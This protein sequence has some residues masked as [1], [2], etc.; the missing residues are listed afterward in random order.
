MKRI[1]L[2]ELEDLPWFPG[3]LRDGGTSYLALALRVSGHA[4][5]LAPKL[6]EAL[7]ATGSTEIIDLCSGGGG[8]VGILSEALAAD[9]NPVKIRLT[10][11]YP[12]V[13]ALRHTAEGSGGRIT[14]EATPVDAT[15]VP[16]SL[17]GFR[18]IFNAFHHF[19][20]DAARRILADA[21]AARRPIG[22]FEVVS[23][24]ALPLFAMLT[25]PLVV[26]LTMPFWRPFRWQWILWT[27]LVPVMPL[28]VLWD[29][30]VS[31]LRVYD[32]DELRALVAGI[33]APDYAWEIGRIKLGDAP[34][35][36]T[37]LIGRPLAPAG[38]VT[39]SAGTSG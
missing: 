23:R 36:A 24:E 39:A 17:T 31:W 26:M 38:A 10:D 35:H 29:G 19:R 14:F 3:I 2:V 7:R 22:V 6:G 32:E 1:H 8:P 11:F 37:W 33:D 16:A 9:G 5:L 28:F 4:K 27:W 25:A 15:A 13:P 21:A 34:A 18:T 20:P 30:I 12:N